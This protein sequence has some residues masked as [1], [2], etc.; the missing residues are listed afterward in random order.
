MIILKKIRKCISFILY[1]IGSLI[2]N[3]KLKSK[4]IITKLKKGVK[5]QTE[6]RVGM[7]IIKLKRTENWIHIK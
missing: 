4:D 5:S 7:K 2:L 1:L 6:L 3:M